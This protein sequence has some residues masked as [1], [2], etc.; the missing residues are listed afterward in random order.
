MSEQSSGSALSRLDA[1]VDAAFA[2]ALTL[3]VIGGGA[4]PGTYGELE[5]AVANP[6]AAAAG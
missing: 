1:F 2:F 5:R 6:P 4:T 3:L